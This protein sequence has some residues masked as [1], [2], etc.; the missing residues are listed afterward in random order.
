M[1]SL[2]LGHVTT[3]SEGILKPATRKSNQKPLWGCLLCKRNKPHEHEKIDN[4]AIE[5]LPPNKT[6]T[7]LLMKDIHK[8]FFA[9][10]RGRW[11]TIRE[12][13][14]EETP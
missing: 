9:D 10:Y 7:L 5:L 8:I 1:L 3:G 14:R 12:I 13:D 11:Y 6:R 2:S 4:P